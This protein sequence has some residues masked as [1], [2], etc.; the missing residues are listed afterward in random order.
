MIK[1]DFSRPEDESPM[2]APSYFFAFNTTY[3][4]NA[5]R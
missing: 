4:L 1:A 2:P 3:E 5:K